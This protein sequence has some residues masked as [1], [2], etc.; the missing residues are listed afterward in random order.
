[1]RKSI[2]TNSTSFLKNLPEEICMIIIKKLRSKDRF[3]LCEVCKSFKTQ[4]KIR[5]SIYDLSHTIL[6]EVHK[7]HL[8]YLS[9]QTKTINDSIAHNIYKFIKENT[10]FKS[11]LL[12]SIFNGVYQIHMKRSDEH[13]IRISTMLTSDFLQYELENINLVVEFFQ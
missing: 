11:R 10:T 1:M 2:K 6:T 8:K 12:I 4:Y 13:Y 7:K 9:K 3:H 5:Q